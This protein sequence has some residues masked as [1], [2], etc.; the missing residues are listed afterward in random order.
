MYKVELVA[1]LNTSSGAVSSSYATGRVAGVKNNTG[2]L[3]GDSNGWVVASWT[4][5][6]VT[7]GDDVGGVVGEN[8]GWTQNVLA[9]GTVSG[10]GHAHGVVGHTENQKDLESLGVYYNSDRHQV[11]DFPYSRSLLALKDPTGYSGIYAKWNVDTDRRPAGASSP[12]DP[13]DFS[14][15]NELPALKADRNGDGIATWQEFGRQRRGGRD[16]DRDDDNLI[17]VS[18]LAQL[19]SIRYD[20]AGVGTPSTAASRAFRDPAYNMGCA[21]KCQGYELTADLN[22]DTNRNGRADAGDYYWND[23]QGWRPIGHAGDTAYSGEFHGNGRSISNLF[24]NRTGSQV[25]LFGTIGSAAYVHH[26]GL[27]NV[28]IT[29]AGYYVGALVGYMQGNQTRVSANYAT[30]RVVGAGQ[31]GGLVGSNQGY[32]R[33]SWAEVSVHGTKHVG[34]LVGHNAG[35]VSASYALGPVRGDSWVHGVVGLTDGGV[36]NEVYFRSDINPDIDDV[37]AKTKA[38][39]ATPTDYTGIYENWDVDLDGD[40]TSDDPWDFWTERRYPRLKADRN[41]DGRFNRAEFRGQNPG[42]ISGNLADYDTDTDN[43]IEV[44]NLGQLDAIRHDLNGDGELAIASVR[45]Y[46]QVYPNPLAGMGCLDTCVGYELTAD[47]DF[48]TNGNGDSDSGDDDWNGGAGWDPIGN[49]ACAYTGEFNGNGRSISNLHI[50]R[51]ENRIGLFGQIGGTG[52]VHHVG[53]PNV[54]IST[55]GYDVGALVGFMQGNQTALSVSFATGLVA[56][57][58]QVGG[59]VGSNQGAVVASWTEVNVFGTKHVGGLIGHKS[60]LVASAYALGAAVGDERVHGAVGWSTGSNLQNVYFNSDV[61]RTTSDTIH[62]KTTAELQA[63]TDYQGIY[64]EWNVDTNRGG[65]VDDP[66]DFGTASD[67]PRLKADRNGDGIATAQEFPGQEFSEQSEQSV[68]D[69]DADNDNLIE[70]SN[71]D[72][73]NALRFDLDGDGVQ[74]LR[75]SLSGPHGGIGLPGHLHRL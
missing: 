38:E 40:G 46:E 6:V 66:W 48:D 54:S 59:L 13:W 35:D 33:A 34:G 25:G 18:N 39:L 49:A 9:L 45:Q 26:V 19:N 15:S 22:F 47:L 74:V 56:G 20:P 44:T 32:V 61:H 10:S 42:D 68:I 3:V 50:D 65:E 21:T 57:S 31:T 41:G 27:P 60:G 70:V 69:Y 2:G 62:P 12:D 37:H 4:D 55:T 75:R 29:S 71:L 8:S 72:Q 73:L 53:L 17:E 52:F 51:T 7:G 36:L 24:I 30:G 1:H 43:L 28:N 14:T 5:T 23:G 11:D 58:G 16:H 67:Y 63:P 64:S